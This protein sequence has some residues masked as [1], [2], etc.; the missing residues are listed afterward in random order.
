VVVV[1]NGTVLLKLTDYLLC[2]ASDLERK[3]FC[4]YLKKIHVF[5]KCKLGKIRG[6]H[7]DDIFIFPYVS[8][9][10]VVFGALDYEYFT[11]NVAFF[12]IIIS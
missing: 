3:G 2:H 10:D 4:H 5:P 12:R 8:I 1:S 9:C 6:F 7:P 11:P